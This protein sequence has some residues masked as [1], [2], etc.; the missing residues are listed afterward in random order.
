MAVRKFSTAS[1]KT[2]TKNSEF[3]DN[4]TGI[5]AIES[6][7]SFVPNT[8]TSSF[9][10]DDIPQNYKHLQI[11]YRISNDVAAYYVRGWFNIMTETSTSIYSAHS[12][13]TDFGTLTATADINQPHFF[14]PRGGDASGIFT[15]GVV[16]IFDYSNPNKNTHVK[17]WGGFSKASGGR[18]E[19]MSGLYKSTSAITSI[20]I[21]SF[22]GKYIAGSRIDLYG[23]KG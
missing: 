15:H 23:V 14:M 4:S 21:N 2:G 5:G 1:I 3:W 11:R 16:D 13:T 12:I 22:T 8:A 18:M 20:T 9:T 6:I 17:S 19:A 7:A 10:F